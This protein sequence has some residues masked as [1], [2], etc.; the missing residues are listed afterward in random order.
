MVERYERKLDSHFAND[1]FYIT[2]FSLADGK[3][4]F[5]HKLT[6]A[7]DN[8]LQA[9]RVW[10]WH[11]NIVLWGYHQE[12]PGHLN[13]LFSITI[14]DSQGNLKR[15]FPITGKP[16]ALDDENGILVCEPFPIKLSSGDELSQPR[17]SLMV[18]AVS[19][20]NGNAFILRRVKEKK[21]RHDTK[22]IFDAYV[23]KYSTDTWEKEWVKMLSGTENAYSIRIRY[24]N[25]LLWYATSVKATDS[26]T[27]KRQIEWLSEPL[28]AATGDVVAG[29]PL[30]PPPQTIT[31][32]D[33]KRYVVSK[34]DEGLL[35]RVV[36]D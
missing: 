5:R 7:G 4:L 31:D 12:Q 21:D 13:E 8:R 34:E 25:G 1:L 33:G 9:A 15:Q 3:R 16:K 10:T 11:E 18:D 35:V 19:D 24:A 32:T 17:F 22:D 29:G 27:Y 36:T 20:G 23:E 26:E 6:V 2:A 28:E 14:L 30:A